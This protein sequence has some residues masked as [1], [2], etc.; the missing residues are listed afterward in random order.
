MCW[1]STAVL[2]CTTAFVAWMQHA[3]VSI[4]N[5]TFLELTRTTRWTCFP[6]GLSRTGQRGADAR[7]NFD[8]EA[9][10][11]DLED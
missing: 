9:S 3:R 5:R 2:R 10:R 4:G 7:A 8:P 6:M 11:Q 1:Q